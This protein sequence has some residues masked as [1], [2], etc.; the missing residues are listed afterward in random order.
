LEISRLLS[1]TNALPTHATDSH[2]AS[3]QSPSFDRL[4]L[5]TSLSTRMATRRILQAPR[6]GVAPEGRRQ[7]AT[8]NPTARELWL[9]ARFRSPLLSVPSCSH[10]PPNWERH[11]L[12]YHP[13]RSARG[14]PVFTVLPCRTAMYDAGVSSI[15]T[16]VPHTIRV[17]PSSTT[18]H[19]ILTQTGLPRRFFSSGRTLAGW[20]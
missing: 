10:C 1:R 13:L 19:Q 17:P 15:P 6:D 2:P 7:Y 8:L 5:A 4:G 12:H 20:S 9:H 14:G 16:F 11:L 3:I 18:R